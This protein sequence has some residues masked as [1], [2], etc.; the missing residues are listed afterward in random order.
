M[1]VVLL[2]DVEKLGDKGEVK[3]VRNGFG[4]NYLLPRGLA[5]AA[6]P[7]ALKAVKNE[8]DQ[9]A[10]RFER[11][12]DSLL[13]TVKEIEK[14]SVTIESG[15]GKEGKLFGAVTAVDIAKAYK[16]QHNETIDR[17]HIK[18]DHPLK[19][20]G[21]HKV[22]LHFGPGVDALLTVTITSK[23]GEP[24]DESKPAKAKAEAKPSKEKT[25]KAK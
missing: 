4:R 14:K 24:K 9:A 10:S 18:L 12:K 8:Q 15:A 20:L 16:T 2:Q 17:K 23:D 5:I 21:E 1:K 3:V 6:T 11:Q 7:G 19:A 13:K 22:P 25:A